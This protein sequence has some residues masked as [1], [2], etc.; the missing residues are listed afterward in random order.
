MS[1]VSKGRR[2]KMKISSVQLIS[3]LILL[4]LAAGC[5]GVQHKPVILTPGE[6]LIM[7][8]DSFKFDPNYFSAHKGDLLTIEVENVSSRDHNITIKTPRGDTLISKNLPPTSRTNIKI[9]LSELGT[10]NFYCDK[11]FHSTMGMKGRI[12]V[13]S[14]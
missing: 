7:K 8:A 14:P 10:Y 11:P 13:T 5:A 6:T 2:I 3:V 4:V 9:N 12:E 1:P